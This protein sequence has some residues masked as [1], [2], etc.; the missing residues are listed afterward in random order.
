MSYAGVILLIG[1]LI[2]LTSSFIQYALNLTLPAMQASLALSYTDAGLLVTAAWTCRL[3]C[4]FASGILVPRYGSRLI[5]GVSTLVGGGGLLLLGLAA[6]FWATLGAMLIVGAASGAA[7]TPMMGLLSS[8]F[9]AGRRGLAA[10][11]ASAG[12]SLAFVVVGVLVPWLSARAPGVG[13]RHSWF[14]FGIATVVGGILAVLFLRDRPAVR[15]PSR[16]P[17][18]A[19]QPQPGVWPAAVYK[20]TLVW[21]VTLLVFCSG[22]AQAIFNTFFGAYLAQEHGIDLAEVGRLLI[23]VGALSIGSGIVWGRVSDQVGRGLA[24]LLV[25]LVQAVGFSLVWLVPGRAMFIIAAVL[26][27]LTLRASFTICAAAAGDYVPVH[28]SAPAFALMGVGAGLGNI[29]APALAGSLADTSGTLRWAFALA[30]GSMLAGAA[31]SFVLYRLT[32]PYDQ[33]A[34]SGHARLPAPAPSVPQ[35]RHR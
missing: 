14:V 5:I 10:G 32:P 6:D 25:F 18:S 7:L 20:N 2:N 29:L 15:E 30:M 24:F 12:G 19:P 9:D 16:S 1:V 27:G 4:T 22:S 17:V 23:L 3:A 34:R 28:L 31:G 21:L 35:P 13:W 26:M 33:A 11:L 8:W